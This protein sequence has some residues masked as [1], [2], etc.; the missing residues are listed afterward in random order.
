MKEIWKDIKG[1]E[2]K[3]QISNLG[4]VKSFPRKGARKTEHILKPNKNHRGYL[5]IHLQNNYKR[6][7]VVLHRLVAEAFIPNPNNLPQVDHID[8]NKENNKV[9]NLQWITNYDNMRKSWETGAR[10]LEKSYKRGKEH[11]RAKKIIQYDKK[12][13]YI[14]TWDCILEA[15]RVLKI[16]DKNICACAKG[17]RPTAYNYIWKY[18]E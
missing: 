9:S 5:I 4:R 17:K 14:K 2:G 3:Y 18:G 8:D 10:S 12:G 1:Y 16:N 6:K 11:P 13:N 7:G 15:S